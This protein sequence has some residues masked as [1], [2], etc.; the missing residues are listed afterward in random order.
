VVSVTPRPRFTPWERTPGTHWTGGWVGS[1]AGLD[2]EATGKIVCPW[3][4]NPD[5]PVVQSLARQ[6]TDWATPAH[7]TYKCNN[8]IIIGIIILRNNA[9]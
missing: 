2:T 6:Y 4:S 9:A 3:G 7:K 1:R 5:R 8:C